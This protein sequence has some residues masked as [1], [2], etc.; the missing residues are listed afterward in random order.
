MCIVNG[1]FML[2]IKDIALKMRSEKTD[3]LELW[4]PSLRIHSTLKSIMYMG[5]S[6]NYQQ[7]I[8]LNPES[9][10]LIILRHLCRSY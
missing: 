5:F 7:V 4:N 1:G 6:P 3:G 10:K 9:G 8:G 2:N